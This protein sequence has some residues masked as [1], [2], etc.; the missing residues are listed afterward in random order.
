MSRCVSSALASPVSKTFNR[1][2][3]E[4]FRPLPRRQRPCR[5]RRSVREFVRVPEKSGT[6]EPRKRSIALSLRNFIWCFAEQSF[7]SRANSSFAAAERVQLLSAICGI[8]AAPR[9]FDCLRPS[10]EFHAER[11]NPRTK[12]FLAVEIVC[13]KERESFLL[14][15]CFAEIFRNSETAE[16]NRL[17]IHSFSKNLSSDSGEGMAG[18][19]IVCARSS[20]SAVEKSSATCMTFAATFLRRS[21]LI[22]SGRKNY[23]RK[24]GNTF[25]TGFCRIETREQFTLKQ[26]REK[27]LRQILRILWR[28][29]VFQA[30]VFVDGLPVCAKSV[31]R[32]RDRS[33]EYQAARSRE[34]RNAVRGTIRQARS[35]VRCGI[36][37]GRVYAGSSEGGKEPENGASTCTAP[38]PK[39]GRLNYH[40]I[41]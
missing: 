12:Y 19:I 15:A 1:S 11:P 28:L 33:A 27:S 20:S 7:A 14:A 31:S 26:F 6:L 8:P 21:G 5:A 25:A 30:E 18:R 24:R 17:R 16:E 4:A 38:A 34:H 36:S 10:Q 13:F 37:F 39:L 29:R 22:S 3:D 23:P 41:G 35:W 9:P 40:G 2:G 32:A